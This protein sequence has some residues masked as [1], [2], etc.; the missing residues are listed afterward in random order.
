MTT[1]RRSFLKNGAI[2]AIAGVSLGLGQTTFAASGSV[3][4]AANSLPDMAAFK[5]QLKT[6]FLIGKKKIPV[7]L[8]NVSNL[9]QKRTAF[10][11]REAFTLTFRAEP[12]GLQQETYTIEHG[13]LGT[14][15]LLIVP[16][17]SKDKNAQY[18]EAV[19]N[20]LHG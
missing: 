8:I 9:G 20:R 3:A 6:D 18:Y 7:R 10:G 5:A 2:G 13:K 17:V 12:R 19:I 4:A 14:F 1:S 11:K 16:I 15:S